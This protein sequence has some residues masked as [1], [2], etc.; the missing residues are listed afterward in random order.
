MANVFVKFWVILQTSQFM[1]NMM[2]ALVINLI[3]ITG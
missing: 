3:K 2:L 1:D